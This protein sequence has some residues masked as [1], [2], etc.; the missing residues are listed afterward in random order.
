MQYSDRRGF[1]LIELLVVVA[2][3]GML[4]GVVLASLN[5][6]RSKGRDARR[7]SDIKSIQSALELSYDAASPDEYPDATSSLTPTHIPSVPVDPE[8]NA[9]YSYDNLTSAGAACAT[10]TGSC[11]SYVLGATLEDT[12]HQALSNDIDGTV[13]SMSCADPVYCVRP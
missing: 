1:T 10:A 13:G 5:T 4:A 2:I 3:I 7:I 8:T 9:V 6:A 12:T 11:G